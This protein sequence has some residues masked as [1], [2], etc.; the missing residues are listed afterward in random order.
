MCVCI[1]WALIKH[2]TCTCHADHQISRAPPPHNDGEFCLCWRRPRHQWYPKSAIFGICSEALSRQINYMI[3]EYGDNAIISV[4]HH[5]WY[6]CTPITVVGRIRIQYLLWRVITQGNH[7]FMTQSSAP[8]QTPQE[9]HE[10]KSWW[11]NGLG[12]AGNSPVYTAFNSD[13]NPD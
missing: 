13:W 6:S 5:W 9:V 11:S 7:T 4:L 12:R 2:N 10:D 8:L 3:D 1:R